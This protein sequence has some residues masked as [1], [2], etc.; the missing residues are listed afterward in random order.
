MGL[1]DS[2]KP[3][4]PA[5]NSAP[6]NAAST[7]CSGM[8]T[9]NPKTCA[10]APKTITIPKNINDS[11]AQLWKDSFPGG[12]SQEHGGTIVQDD[13]G[14]V[15]MVNTSNPGDTGSFSANRNV[16]SNQKII[17]TFH[18]HPYDESEGGYT[19]V[20]FSGA[21]IAN[22][23]NLR[24]PSYVQSGDKQFALFPTD[25]T[26]K[27]VDYNKLNKDQNDRI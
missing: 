11:M 14:N 21:D 9:S 16:A 4:P 3:T 13:K 2:D 15:S 23:I 25:D 5:N 10:D 12:K 17:G 22:R 8:P 6:T 27:S 18:T 20:S 7:S 26:P 19:G 1:C 24:E